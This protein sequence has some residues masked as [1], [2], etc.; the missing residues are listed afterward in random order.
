VIGST[1]KRVVRGQGGVTL[2]ELVVVMPMLTILLGGLT[3]ALVRTMHW[4]DQVTEQTVQQSDARA[5]LSTLVSDL[6]QAYKGDGVPV[7]TFSPSGSGGATQITFYSPDRTTPYHLRMISYRLQ[8]GSLQ[9]QVTAST[10][11]DGPPWTFPATG[12]WTT[13]LMKVVNSDIFKLYDSSDPAVQ[14]TSTA[15]VG[16]IES[17]VVKLTVSTGG[18]QPRITTFSD[19]ASIRRTT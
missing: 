4:N 11:T 18:Q 14:L 17:V 19:T 2:M 15:D 3:F 16:L 12:P 9:R 13:V 1:F 8:N 10:N 6:R 7:S 5:A